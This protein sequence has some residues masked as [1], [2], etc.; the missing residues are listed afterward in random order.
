MLTQ[1]E[2]RIFE[3]IGKGEIEGNRAE[4]LIRTGIDVGQVA[5][6]ISS[7]EALRIGHLQKLSKIFMQ[8]T[9]DNWHKY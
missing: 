3:K 8:F 7:E 1:S 4:V 2:Q 9:K 6:A 5:N